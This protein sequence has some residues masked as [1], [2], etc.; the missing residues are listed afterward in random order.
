MSCTKIL[1]LAG[2]RYAR[3]EQPADGV[4]DRVNL[5]IVNEPDVWLIDGRNKTG[6]HSTNSGPDFRVHNPILGPDCPDELFGFEFGHEVDF[7]KR[8][9]VKTLGFKQIGERTCATKQFAAKNYL[10]TVSIDTKKNVPVE[11]KAFLDGEMKFTVE[12]LNYEIGLPFN[13]SL[14]EPP[15]DVH[16][17]ETSQ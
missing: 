14:F 10:V 13:S 2:D 11:L 3:V 12:Y 6:N 9:G 17:S 16:V 15:K 1:Y 7:L 8:A 4:S 5:I